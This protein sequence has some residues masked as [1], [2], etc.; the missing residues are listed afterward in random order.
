MKVVFEVVVVDMG[1]CVEVEI[2]VMYSGFKY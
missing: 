2:E 1:G